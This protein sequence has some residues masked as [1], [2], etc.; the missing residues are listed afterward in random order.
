MRNCLLI[1][2]GN[3]QRCPSAIAAAGFSK[4]NLENCRF[5]GFNFTIAYSGGSEGAISD[6]LIL[7]PGHCG[8]TVY[9]GSTIDVARN[10]ITGSRY[11]GV[12]S[13]G[14]TLNMH[15]N[16]IIRNKN[17]GIYLGNKS[18][19][20]RVSNNVILGNG[21]GISAFA[22]TDVTIENN[23]ILDSSYAGLG[24]RDSCR[25]T[26]KNNL[27]QDNTRGIVLSE[28]TGRTYVD[29]G[30]NSFW[31][32][33]TDTENLEIPPT[34]ILVDPRLTAPEDGNFIPQAE[35]LAANRQGLSDAE[36]FLHLWEKWQHVSQEE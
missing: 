9:S 8:I 33:K 31:N 10:I 4:V 6:C 29:V 11:H 34:S 1:A 28:E 26:V 22:Q 18:A 35:E 30:Q 14:G 32:N 16:L 19:R 13:T 7:N 20:G 25:I 5:E 17:R 21:T 24:T 12:R 23:L 15:D 3:D 36:V 27:F 2:L